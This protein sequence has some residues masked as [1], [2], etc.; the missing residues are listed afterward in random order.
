MDNHFTAFNFAFSPFIESDIDIPN[1]QQLHLDWVRER[2]RER[3]EQSTETSEREESGR[4]A[5]ETVNV[6]TF[7]AR[8]GA[9]EANTAKL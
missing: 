4:R 6:F 8:I 9:G 1:I 7:L 2:Q 3:A 5:N